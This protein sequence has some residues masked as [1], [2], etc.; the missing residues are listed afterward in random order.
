MH[1]NRVYEWEGRGSRESHGQGIKGRAAMVSHHP[2][3]V[4]CGAAGVREGYRFVLLLGTRQNKL[5]IARSDEKKNI[6][7]L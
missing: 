3:R 4:S 2:F 5:G 7:H 1:P 6:P